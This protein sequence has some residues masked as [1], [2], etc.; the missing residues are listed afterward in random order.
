MIVNIHHNPKCG[1]KKKI[2]RDKFFRV[3]GQ[4]QWGGS[5][6]TSAPPRLTHTVLL[7]DSK[8]VQRNSD[9]YFNGFLYR[10]VHDLSKR[11][12]ESHSYY[13]HDLRRIL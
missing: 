4:L 3:Y 2:N 13:R 12:P 11:E 10:K 7:S 8:A 6:Y 5:R 9:F 1:I